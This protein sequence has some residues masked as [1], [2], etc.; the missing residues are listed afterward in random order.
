MEWDR[1]KLNKSRIYLES[2]SQSSDGYRWGCLRSSGGNFLETHTPVH[3][4]RQAWRIVT[5]QRDLA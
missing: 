4:S 5:D 1:Y 3:Q 2:L